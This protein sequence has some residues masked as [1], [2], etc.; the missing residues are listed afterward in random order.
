MN[1]Q[2]CEK[3]AKTLN[4]L[5]QHEVRCLSN[6]NGKR[7]TWTDAMKLKHSNLMKKVN[8]NANTVW[9]DEMRKRASE[10]QK[11][12]QKKV[13]SNI[14]LR[15]RHSDIMQK[16]VKAN[17]DAYSASNV[18]GRTK[19]LDYNGFKL[20]GTWELEVAQ[21][22]DSLCIKWTN[23]L[24]GFNYTWENKNHTYFP[25]FYLPSYDVYLEVKGYETERDRCKWK[26][27]PNKLI[28]VKLAEIQ[29]IKAGLL[30]KEYIAGW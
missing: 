12:V 4:S 19:T 27:F 22:L 24:Q 10:T 28:V 1:C 21:W 11:I 2:Y 5:R 30:N 16:V 14:E 17:P 13:W 3:P 25:D 20:K 7:H 9:T 6:P 29:K 15:N 26:D 18:S 23:K 8:N